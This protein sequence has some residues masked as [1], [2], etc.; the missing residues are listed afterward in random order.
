[1]TNQQQTLFS[2]VKKMKAF[3]LRSGRRHGCP[4]LLL[5]IQ[6]SF[7]N[8]SHG[9]QEQKEIKEIQIGKEVVKLS[10]FADDMILHTENPK[11]TTKKLANQLI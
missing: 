6:Y 3:S 5:L 9:N 8:P 11:Y 4:L 10:V 7:G 2:M 1:M